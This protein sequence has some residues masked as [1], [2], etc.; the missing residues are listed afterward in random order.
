MSGSGYPQNGHR[1]LPRSGTAE[2]DEY[3]LTSNSTPKN[4]TVKFRPG[5][6]CDQEITDGRKVKATITVDGNTLQV[7][8]NADGFQTIIDRIFSDYEIKMVCNLG[9]VTASRIYKLQA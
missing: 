9:E 8:K 4:L 1:R 6:E 3:V 7:Q 5:V 2:V